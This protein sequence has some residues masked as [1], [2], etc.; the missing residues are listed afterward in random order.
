MTGISSLAQALGQIDRIQSQQTL[1]D[2]L[3]TQL[4]TGKKTQKFSGL[5]TEILADQRART[6]LSA[7]ETYVDNIRHQGQIH[8]QSQST[9]P[10]RAQDRLDH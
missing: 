7:L 3:S 10:V 9:P 8:S 2:E 4:A 1:L 6:D 5:N